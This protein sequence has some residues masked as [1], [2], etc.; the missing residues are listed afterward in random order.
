LQLKSFS[1]FERFWFTHRQAHDLRA[2]YPKA[3]MHECAQPLRG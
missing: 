1:Y 2:P 3:T